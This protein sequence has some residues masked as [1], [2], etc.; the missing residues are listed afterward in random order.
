MALLIILLVIW[1]LVALARK[2]RERT[3]PKKSEQQQADELI[4]VILPTINRDR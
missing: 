2:G 4:T 1:L 3:A